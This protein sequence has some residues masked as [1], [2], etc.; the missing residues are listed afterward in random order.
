M[1]LPLPATTTQRLLPSLTRLDSLVVY[2][3]ASL[4][5]TFLVSFLF[6]KTEYKFPF[7]HVV[8]C[9]QLAIAWL[10][11]SKTPI[12]SLLPSSPSSSLPTATTTTTPLQTTRLL[13]PVTAAYIGWL[14][15]NPL[16]LIH[17]P[18]NAYQI[19]T[20]LALPLSHI[21]ISTS[22]FLKKPTQSSSSSLTVDTLVACGLYY[23]GFWL[24]SEGFGK[25]SWQGTFLG[26]FNA[27]FL[28]LYGV[29]AK[30]SLISVDPWTLVRHNSGWGCLV[31]IPFGI[32]NWVTWPGPVPSFV[33]ELG[34]WFQM[35]LTGSIGLGLQMITIVLIK[36]SSP[37]M[38]TSAA[39]VKVCLQSV[40]A[41]AILGNPLSK[42]NLFGTAIALSGACYSIY[43]E[44][45]KI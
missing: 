20:G 16:F 13:F 9:I 27:F 3:V 42:L 7:P 10:I 25:I 17:V 19:F 4:F 38:Q 24:S 39:G 8:N 37:I 28:A 14:V 31:M 40:L 1:L 23:F 36:L 15:V 2:I 45:R 33:D 43:H 30:K 29:L 41:A 5:A 12:A 6:T 44:L 35:V 11:A 18:I 32:Y 21:L 26:L 34:F 22:F